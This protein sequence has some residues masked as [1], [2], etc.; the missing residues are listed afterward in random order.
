MGSGVAVDLVG[1]ILMTIAAER[2]GLVRPSEISFARPRREALTALATIAA[3]IA[4]VVVVF[5]ILFATRGHPSTAINVA[6]PRYDVGRLGVQLALLAVAMLP[7]V[8]VVVL[9]RQG[10]RTIGLDRHGIGPQVA[11]GLLLA[12]LSVI[13]LGKLA[14]ASGA[15]PPEVLRL[16]AFLG[17]GLQEEVS[18]R[19]F[20]QARVVG[21]LGEYRGWLAASTIFALAHIPQDLAVLGLGPLE[22]VPQMLIQLVF[23]LVFG[24]IALRAGG[25]TAVALF[26]GALD[27][28][29]WL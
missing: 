10:A 19:G 21:W 29:G 11:L 4:F 8:A 9:R 17:V 16:V 15:G 27:W 26:H 24:W 5:A 28:A 6:T 18:Y 13:A 12:A 14:P 22:L 7:V 20:L 3:Q 23:G 25:V 1:A 2:V